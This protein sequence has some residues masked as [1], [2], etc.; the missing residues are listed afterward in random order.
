M[1]GPLYRRQAPASVLDSDDKEVISFAL[2][3]RRSGWEEPE[4]ADWE[5]VEMAVIINELEVVLE[6]PGATP[7]GAP[8]SPPPQSSSQQIHPVDLTDLRE[9]EAR[10]KW[11][12]FAH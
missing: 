12:L 3:V 2:E 1:A 6:Q 11:R 9:R 5:G 4:R 8:V 7:P 10:V